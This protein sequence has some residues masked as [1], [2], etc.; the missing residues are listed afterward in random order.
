VRAVHRPGRACAPEHLRLR[1]GL[2]TEE[3][4]VTSDD[5]IGNVVN[6]AARVTALAKGGQVVVT[7]DTLAAAGELPDVRVLRARCLALKRVA[8]RT[9]VSRVEQ[10]LR[11]S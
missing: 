9:T 11:G 2:H 3:V 5:L 10:V 6:I 1:A 8:A 4:V 7:A